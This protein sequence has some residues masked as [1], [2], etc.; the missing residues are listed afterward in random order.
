[1]PDGAAVRITAAREAADKAAAEECEVVDLTRDMLLHCHD[2]D[3]H[4]CLGDTMAAMRSLAHWP[5]LVKSPSSKSCAAAHI[6]ACA[7]CIAKQGVPYIKVL[8]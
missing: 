7:H 4:S 6:D 5:D 2:N 3:G 1:M 8:G